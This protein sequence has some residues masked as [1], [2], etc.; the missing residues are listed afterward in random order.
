MFSYPDTTETS[1]AALQV[2]PQLRTVHFLGRGGGASVGHIR[3][4][5]PFF[6]AFTALPPLAHVLPS[7]ATGGDLTPR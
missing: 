6:S 7:A 2:L 5:E 4:G 1:R 3:S